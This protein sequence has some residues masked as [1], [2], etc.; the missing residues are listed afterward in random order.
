[1]TNDMLVNHEICVVE[2]EYDRNT[3]EHILEM[4]T[5]WLKQAGV[6]IEE[7]TPLEE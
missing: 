3:I 6:F 7:G 4:E 1:M 5:E 2:T